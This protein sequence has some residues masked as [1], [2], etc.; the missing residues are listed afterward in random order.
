M[1]KKIKRY[2]Q[3]RKAIQLEVLET[4]CTICLYLDYEGH[5]SR[6]RYAHYMQ[7]HFS[8]LKELSRDLGGRYMI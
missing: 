7:G 8:R 3:L 6:N 1:F 2:L 4:L 5:Y